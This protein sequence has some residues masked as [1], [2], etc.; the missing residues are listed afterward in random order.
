[1]IDA[2]LKGIAA[3]Y[4][5]AIPIG[6]I[7][8]LI[9]ES[10]LRRGFL[11]ALAAGAGT[12]SADGIYAAVVAAFGVALA[13]VIQPLERPLQVAAVVLLILIAGLGLRTAFGLRGLRPGPAQPEAVSPA[14]DDVVR[15]TTG[16]LERSAG[17]TYALFLGLTLL[18]P[19]TVVYFVAMIVGIGGTGAGPAEKS[20]FVVGA[21]AASLSWQS[22]LAAAGALLHRRL[23]PGIRFGVSVL[24]NVI[25]LAFAGLIVRDLLA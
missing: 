23:S 25:I 21:F 7:G 4:G 14:L 18:N 3:G 22:F 13:A 16:G 10:G 1:M 11:A 20:A 8:V 2:L 19:V 17:R 24:G 9:V 12:A 5:I 6:A 15:P